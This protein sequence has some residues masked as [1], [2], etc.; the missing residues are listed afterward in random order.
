MGNPYTSQSISGYNQN[1]PSDDGSETEANR[2]KWAT[3]KTKLADALNTFAAAIN[4]E[5]LSAFGQLAWYSVNSQAAP[6]TLV[7]SDE[8]KTVRVTTAGTITL[9]AASAAGLG[10]TVTIF[11][12]S[13]GSVT[14]DGNGAETINGDATFIL[15]SQDDSA[16]LQ[17]DGSNWFVVSKSLT[18]EQVAY[19]TYRVFS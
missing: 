1:P 9:L 17:C 16:H 18:D 11:N 8:R 3:I 5:T 15:P 19:F 13:S 4:A 7:A 2:T 10:H 14:I 6:Y 12:D